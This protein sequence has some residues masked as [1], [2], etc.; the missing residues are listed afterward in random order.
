MG[1]DA[2]SYARHAACL[3]READMKLTPSLVPRRCSFR[4]YVHE[5]VGNVCPRQIT[6]NYPDAVEKEWTAGDY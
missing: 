5:C 1:E 2:A 6:S 4:D 3:V